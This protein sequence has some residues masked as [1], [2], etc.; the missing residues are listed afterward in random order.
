MQRRDLIR[1]SASARVR[2][3]LLS[4]CEHARVKETNAAANELASASNKDYRATLF[5][6]RS[7]Q[8]NALRQSTN[9]RVGLVLL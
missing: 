6:E 3:L 1:R 8:R 2:L 7:R 9:A 4:S 5:R